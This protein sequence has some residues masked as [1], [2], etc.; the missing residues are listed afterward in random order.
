MIIVDYIDGA[1]GEYMSYFID[2]HKELSN[3]TP[4]QYNMQ[5]P[6]RYKILNTTSLMNSTWDEDF[7]DEYSKIK[8][9]TNVVSYHLYKFPHH[10]D[11]IRRI[12]P[13]VRFVR[14][15]SEDNNKLIKYDFVR[16]IYLR[17]FTNKDLPEI[18][19]LINTF[20]NDKKIAV[21]QKL[22]MGDLYHIDLE[23]IQRNMA[24]TRKNRLDA[25]YDFVDK[26][27]TPPSSDITISYTD[28]FV[29]FAKT[30]AAYQTL[31][32]QLNIEYDSTKLNLLLE[33]N[34][35]NYIDAVKFID[36]FEKQIEKL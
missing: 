30:P 15:D 34:K 16:K 4:D 32:D 12:D 33:R 13:A 28:F 7:A 2:S 31:C 8:N 22:K 27:I 20:D 11:I 1:G 3:Y 26:K 5:T 18:K 6:A 25:I 9:D 35:Q 17:K 14:I 23:L 24:V 21:V 10:I 29:D 36:N 19:I